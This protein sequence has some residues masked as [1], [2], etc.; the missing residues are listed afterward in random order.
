[1]KV[2]LICAKA[3]ETMEF[4][5]FIDVIGWARETFGNDVEVQTCGF[6]KT[7]ISTFGVPV[8]MDV[9]IDEVNVDAYDA[10]ANPGGFREFGFNE[11]AFHPKTLEMIRTFHEQKKPIA[12][13]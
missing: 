6:Q 3:F 8:Q 11:D 2:I 9:L 5:V 12:T 7:V 10:L 1:M 13:V 4:S